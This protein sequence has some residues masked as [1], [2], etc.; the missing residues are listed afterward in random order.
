MKGYTSDQIYRVAWRGGA[1]KSMTLAEARALQARM[2]ESWLE[3][4]NGYE[5]ERV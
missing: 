1:S 5:W 2:P 3:Q 4:W